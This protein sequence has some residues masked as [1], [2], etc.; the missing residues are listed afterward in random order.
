MVQ[1]R[2]TR[3][4]PPKVQVQYLVHWLPSHAEDW[5]LQ[6]FQDANIQ[7]KSA[8]PACRDA[9]QGDACACRICWS[10]D[11]LRRRKKERKTTPLGVG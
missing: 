2:K 5:A 1:C 10:P 11:S 8:T 6:P 7:Y 9:Q 3:K 4:G